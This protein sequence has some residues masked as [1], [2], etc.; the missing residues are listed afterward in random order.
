MKE[1]PNNIWN[2]YPTS[3]RRKAVSGLKLRSLVTYTSD[4]DDVP[5][6]AKRD[7]VVQTFWRFQK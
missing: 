5:P 2:M 7:A 3:Q 6:L 4:C 1:I